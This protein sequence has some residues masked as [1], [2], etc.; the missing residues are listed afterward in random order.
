MRV[1]G[2]CYLPLLGSIRVFANRLFIVVF[3]L[4]LFIYKGR[5]DYGLL[6]AKIFWW[7]YTV[8]TPRGHGNKA[9]R[10]Y[11]LGWVNIT[12]EFRRTV[13]KLP[14]EVYL[15]NWKVRWTTC[16]SFMPLN[17]S[18]VWL[19]FKNMQ[20]CLTVIKLEV[21]LYTSGCCNKPETACK[22]Y[23]FGKV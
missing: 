1:F 15:D 23:K 19:K 12:S 6:F 10:G 22:G 20:N 7:V 16:K 11:S 2:E 17:V 14:G 4:Y 5:I 18:F 21:F 9:R 13:E 3:W 8:V